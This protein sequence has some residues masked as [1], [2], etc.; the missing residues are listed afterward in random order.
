MKAFARI[1]CLIFSLGIISSIARAQYNG[2]S[3]IAIRE[4]L[5]KNAVTYDKL[6]PGNSERSGS[7]VYNR[8]YRG[9]L[10][11]FSCEFYDGVVSRWADFYVDLEFYQSTCS[12]FP[13]GCKTTTYPQPKER[14]VL[15]IGNQEHELNLINRDLNRYYI[16]LSARREIYANPNLEAK[17]KTG[18]DLFPEYRLGKVFLEKLKVLLDTSRELSPVYPSSQ[19]ARSKMERLKEIDELL[20]SGAITRSEY[21]NTRKRILLE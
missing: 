8:E 1:T 10:C 7:I 2:Q 21:D 9:R 11:L 19:F 4:L 5:A 14:V 6:I 17:I 3:Q 15:V 16:P 12:G 18:W 13:G 20:R